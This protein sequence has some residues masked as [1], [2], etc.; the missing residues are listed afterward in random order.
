M[1]S[2]K[3]EEFLRKVQT[4]ESQLLLYTPHHHASLLPLD[5]SE[6]YHE[7][8]HDPQTS[9]QSLIGEYCLRLRDK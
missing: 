1:F 6:S 7:N 4:L 3:E 9:S 8:D 5:Q 2:I